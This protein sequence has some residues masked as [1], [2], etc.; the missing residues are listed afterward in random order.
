MWIPSNLLS[1]KCS[2]TKKKNGLYVHATNHPELK[3]MCLKEVSMNCW[4]LY[5]LN[6]HTFWSL[7]ISTLTWAKKIL[8]QI[9]AIRMISKTLYVAQ[10]VTRGQNQPLLMSF[11]RRNQNVSNTLWMN[12]ASWVIFIMLYVLSQSCFVLQWSPDVFIIEAISTLM[13]NFM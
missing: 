11:C 3:I 4:I 7:E 5:K 10:H 2:F 6:R 13:K 9:C 1:L 8:Y 12:L